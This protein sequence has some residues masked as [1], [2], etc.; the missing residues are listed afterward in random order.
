VGNLGPGT[1]VDGR[2]RIVERR[3]AGSMGIVYRAEDIWLDRPVAIKMVDAAYE[4]D[5]AAS[6]QFQQEARSLAQIRHD[7]VVNVYTFGKHEGAFYF[8]MEYVDGVSLESVIE[9]NAARGDTIELGRATQILRAIGKGLGAVHERKLVHRDVKPGNVV[10]EKDTGRPVLVDFGLARRARTSNPRMTT[11]AGTPSYMAPEQARDVDGTRTTAASD[12]YALAC[13]AF[14]LFTGRAVFEGED[15]YAIL[16]AHLNEAP[17]LI[18][19]LRPELVGLDAVF[20]RAL[21]KSPEHRHQSCAKLLAEID[22]VASDVAAPRSSLRPRPPQRS[23][24]IDAL[25][26]FLLESD[27]GLARQITR[28]AD[29]ALEVPAI[30][31]FTGASELVSAFERCPADIIVLDEEASAGV[32]GAGPPPSSGASTSPCATV[33]SAIRRLARGTAAEIV[34]LSRSW[35]SGP[36]GLAELGVRE[37][38]KPINMQVLVSVLKS[39][40]VRSRTS[41]ST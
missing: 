34:V 21:A 38:P 30:E 13:T 10:I 8:A 18:S 7:N 2:Y 16:L 12:I 40:G 15:I 9:E 33:V 27:A 31:C 11:T 3:G 4:A 36:S 41:R 6:R 20:A 17:P 32:P 1:E 19:S 5:E 29:R 37:L 24:G 35:E 22:E 28:A 14:E 23:V 25:R 26:L 39:A